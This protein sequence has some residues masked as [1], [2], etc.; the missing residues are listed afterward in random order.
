MRSVSQ[1]SNILQLAWNCI[2]VIY[3]QSWGLIEYSQNSNLLETLRK[4]I[5]QNV[6]EL[7]VVIGCSRVSFP[8]E[9]NVVCSMCTYTWWCCSM[10]PWGCWG[11]RPGQLLCLTNGY[12]DK[13]GHTSVSHVCLDTAYYLLLLQLYK[14]LTLQANINNNKYRIGLQ[15]KE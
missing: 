13:Y 9:I 5:M 4:I 1:N 10:W 8:S 2:M 12:S 14:L 6:I 7:T 15:Y 3:I 11:P